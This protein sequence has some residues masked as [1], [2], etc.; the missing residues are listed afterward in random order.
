MTRKQ[1]MELGRIQKAIKALKQASSQMLI[2]DE[3]FDKCSKID[4]WV[5]SLK[6]HELYLK[7][8]QDK[9]IEFNKNNSVVDLAV[10][11]S[12]FEGHALENWKDH[13]QESYKSPVDYLLQ[14]LG[15]KETKRILKE[16][17]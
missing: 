17:E 3:H 16:G 7:I 11:H 13:L 12:D 2:L 14:N 1:K 6:E 5:E 15:E 8:G 10:E 4:L 9:I